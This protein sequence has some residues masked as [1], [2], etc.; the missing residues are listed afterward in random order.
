M[1]RNLHRIGSRRWAL[2][3]SLALIAGILGGPVTAAG[4]ADW[5]MFA[6]DQR[7]TGLSPETTLKAS[8]AAGLGIQWQSNTGQAAYSSPAV[9]HNA[10]L[11]KT[12][13]YVGNATGYMQAF[14]AANG[15]R[16]W[17]FKAGAGINSSPA[18]VGGTIYF[19][20][21][22]EWFY[23]LNAT[24]G[25]LQCKFFTDGVINA[26]PVLVN[27]NGT[28][29]VAYF[30]DNGI[31]G[32]DD[33]GH[34][35]AINAVDP[36]AAPNCSQKWRYSA[37]GNPP[38]SHPES[39]VWSPAAFGRDVNKRPLVF[40][41]GSSTDNAVYALHAVTGARVWRF[42]TEVFHPD[43][44]VGAGPTISPPG[45]NGF[46]DG[47]VYV[48]GK[49]RIVYALN[50][51]T[52]TKIWEFRIRDDAL[53]N[54][55]ATRSTPALVG[56]RLYVGYGSGVYALNA[57][58][59]AKIWKSTDAGEVI[60]SPAVT[61]PAG[62]PADRVL[63]VGDLNGRVKGYNA[64][65]GATVFTYTTGGFIYGS[66]V[67]SGAKVFIASSDGYL[68][69]FRR[70][71][72]SSAK[73]DTTITQPAPG[74]TLPNPAG[75]LQMTGTS[76]DDE[77]VTKVLVAVKNK[78]TNKWWDKTAGAWTPA[79]TQ[80]L[81]TL[82]N[83]PGG[84]TSEPWAF[85]FPAPDAGGAFF[86]QAEAVDADGQ[87]DAPVAQVH[88]T[89]ESSGNPPDTTITQPEFKQVFHFPG[90]IR[91]EFPIEISGTATDPTGTNRGI[92]K[93]QV[94]IRNIEHGEYYCGPGGC[95]VGGES[96]HWRPTYT[97]VLATLASPGAASTNWSYTFLTY[98]HPH[99]YRIT[100]W[101]FDL[102]GESDQ[103]RA[104]VGRICVRDPGDNA[105]V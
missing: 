86:A 61:G 65:T 8:N 97:V 98:D 42:Q 56:D 53:P 50:L 12:L 26:S 19:G 41:G 57:K 7:H 68:Y 45:T 34:M 16:V 15:E 104:V 54:G 55:G 83:P 29:L 4:A 39:G 18:V 37:F 101:A 66:A 9:V 24:T 72:G 38:G 58:T 67:V 78:N 74:S 71:G 43:N 82:T 52:G 32:G 25:A 87:H 33:G 79:F 95:G 63:F 73:P 49:N 11:G 47:V 10:T 20:S 69:A 23:A 27:P 46:A 22:D 48:P 84:G 88:F 85:G 75:D 3:L 91:A 14:D 40:F 76:S 60:P 17:F 103:T 36:N 30:G 105:C 90:G 77:G 70:G 89:V 6:R 21:Q 59:G 92:Q 51:L 13:V 99:K 64:Q 94:V 31:T 102:D 2:G 96:S 35:W 5:P 81:A 1:A 93:V 28:G 100:A 80:N 62:P 44:D